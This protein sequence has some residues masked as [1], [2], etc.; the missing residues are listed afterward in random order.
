MVLPCYNERDYLPLTLAKASAELCLIT[1]DY[2]LIIVDD[3]STDGSGA[4]ARELAKHDP[5]IR[6]ISHER[7]R[8]LGYALRTGFG[9]A[10]NFVIVYTDM[11]MPFD[12]AKLREILPLMREYDFVHGKRTGHRES[13]MRELLGVSYNWLVRVV[14]GIQVDDVNFALKVFRRD[15]L[16]E[17][18]LRSEGSFIDA[19][20]YLAVNRLGKKVRSVEVQYVPR[21]FGQSSLANFRNIAGI[22][23]ELAVE[24]AR[25]RRF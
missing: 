24:C 19:E 1:D 22:L 3:G 7:N 23:R 16:N 12:L 21:R 5:K 2:E 17:I 13:G 10:R 18:E 14:F 8:G 11:D 6:V 20:L 25:R 4:I 9:A 15:L